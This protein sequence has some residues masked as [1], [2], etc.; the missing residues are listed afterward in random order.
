MKENLIKKYTALFGAECIYKI[1]PYINVIDATEKRMTNYILE[2]K[3]EGNYEMMCGAEDKLVT[4]GK[5]IQI[6]TLLINSILGINQVRKGIVTPLP[7]QVEEKA[8]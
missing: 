7:P 5:Y 2:C 6:T 8:S 1:L 4:M 3:K